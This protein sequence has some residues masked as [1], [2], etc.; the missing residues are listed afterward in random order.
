M[1]KVFFIDY[2]EMGKTITERILFKKLLNQLDAQFIEI[3]RSVQKKKIATKSF[4]A[5]SYCS[6]TPII[7]MSYFNTNVIQKSN[8][9]FKK[10][11]TVS[12]NNP[13]NA[14]C[15]IGGLYTLTLYLKYKN[16]SCMT[17]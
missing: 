8:Y 1:Q 10:K 12:L 6:L 3:I 17:Q 16:I 14:V 15:K 9:I 13:L 7:F 5:I 4:L 11:C 2:L